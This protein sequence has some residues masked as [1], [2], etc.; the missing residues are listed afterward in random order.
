[1]LG[2]TKI[3]VIMGLGLVALCAIALLWVHERGAVSERE[4]QFISQLEAY[5][6]Q[7]RKA[8]V[9]ARG[10]EDQLTQLKDANMQLTK[11]LE[12]EINHDAS[13][14]SCQVPVAG[15]KFLQHAIQGGL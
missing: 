6:R 8:D 5:D 9:I 1:M 11:E 12:N 3:D 10:L 15:V 2:I 7:I 4:K 14:R 13:Y